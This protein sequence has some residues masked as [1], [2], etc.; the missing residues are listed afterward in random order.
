MSAPVIT[1][2]LPTYNRAQMLDRCVRSVLATLPSDAEIVVCDDGSTDA[3]GATLAALVASDERVRAL[4]I[5]NAGPAAARNRGWRAARAPIV[6][7]IDDDCVAVAG[8]AA[9]LIR[10][11]NTHPEWVGVEG[12]T[13]PASEQ[14]GFFI[15]TIDSRPGA[16][17]TCNLAVRRDGLERVGGFDEKFP[18]PA[19]E[20][21][22]L[23]LR[24][25]ETGG[26]VGYAD[27]ANVYH[28]CVPVGVAYYLKR[29]KYDASNYRLFARH[30]RRFHEA[31]STSRSLSILNRFGEP[32]PTAILAYFIALRVAWAYGTLRSNRGF[33]ERSVGTATHLVTALLSVGQFPRGT[34]AFREA[35]S[36]R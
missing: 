35:R 8:W 16:F 1:V 6:A 29:M 31:L 23:C 15:H 2:V 17:L 11:L 4:R 30:P 12:K 25:E 7:F 20:D 21:I 10:A 33:R 28:D 26:A 18:F 19:C 14:G 24:L 27:D 32:T 22:D 9:A 5:E 36:T 34:H 13:A 3:T